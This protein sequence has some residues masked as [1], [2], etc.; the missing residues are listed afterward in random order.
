MELDAVVGYND[1]CKRPPKNLVCLLLMLPCNQIAQP[2]IGMNS[3]F[4]LC[5]DP[6]IYFAQ[7]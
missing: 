1:W 7:G 2:E 3:F 5:K 6:N 4:L